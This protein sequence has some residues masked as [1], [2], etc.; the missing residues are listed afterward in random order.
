MYGVIA[1]LRDLTRKIIKITYEIKN[2]K[3]KELNYVQNI[4]GGDSSR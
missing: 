1:S 3:R 2:T 4:S